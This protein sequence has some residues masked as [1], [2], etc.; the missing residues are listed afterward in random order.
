M[1]PK[2]WRNRIIIFIL[3]TILCI[4]LMFVF[5]NIFSQ[6]GLIIAIGVALY[7]IRDCYKG[8][9]EAKKHEVDKNE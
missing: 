8:Y 1:S 5:T 3:A 9:K 4:D 7:G 2:Y 6:I